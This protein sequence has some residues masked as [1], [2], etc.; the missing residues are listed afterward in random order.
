MNFIDFV[1]IWKKSKLV[2]STN[3][4]G[5]TTTIHLQELS[6]FVLI[7]PPS[8]C[9]VLSALSLAPPFLPLY[10]FFVTYRGSEPEKALDVSKCE[11]KC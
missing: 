6:I 10:L 3:Q 2:R 5:L 8:P 9:R 1:W 7:R 11:I 4:K